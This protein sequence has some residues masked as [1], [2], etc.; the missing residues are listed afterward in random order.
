MAI[1]HNIYNN[2][3]IYN[4]IQKKMVTWL[5]NTLMSSLNE[6]EEHT[7]LGLFGRE[8]GVGRADDDDVDVGSADT[9]EEDDEDGSLGVHVDNSHFSKIMASSGKRG[10]LVGCLSFEG[11]L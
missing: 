7:S 2:N 9:E 10:W 1:Y 5:A 11:C 3:K 4:T 6:S 8:D